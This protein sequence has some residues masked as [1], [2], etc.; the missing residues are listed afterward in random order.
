MPLLLLLLAC[1]GKTIKTE[2]SEGHRHSFTIP[3]EDLADPPD[4]GVIL[5]TT[6][7]DGHTHDV[8]LSVVSLDLLSE[9][10]GIGVSGETSET[11][12]HSHE[13]HGE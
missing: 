9:R 2:E 3:R 11:E 10:G 5:E 13:W 4:S 8:T 6:E 7:V 12:A 1:G